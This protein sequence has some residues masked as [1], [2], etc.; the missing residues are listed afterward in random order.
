MDNSN[1]RKTYPWI[2]QMSKDVFQGQHEQGPSATELGP[3]L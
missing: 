1:I 3:S 2:C